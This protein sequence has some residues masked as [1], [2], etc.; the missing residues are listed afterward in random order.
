MQPVSNVG[1][2][3]N[4]LSQEPELLLAF[5]LG[6]L[7]IIAVTT[8]A[9]S[10]ILGAK[11]KKVREHEELTALKLQMLEKGMSSAEIKEVVSA[12]P[13]SSWYER[14]AGGAMKHKHGCRPREFVRH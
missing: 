9:V 4:T 3:I 14:V 7:G 2:I 5:L 11:W 10:A 13:Q 6:S 1:Q 12:A 8:I